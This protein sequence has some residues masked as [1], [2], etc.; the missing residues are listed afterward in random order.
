MQTRKSKP[1]DGPG[2]LDYALR[3]L[4]G[5]ALSLAEMR[6]RLHRRA[7]TPSDVE[8]VLAKL[9]DAGY[10][11]DSRFAESYATARRDTQGFG[12][13][14]VLRDLRTRKVPGNLA[15]Q[16]VRDAFEEVDETAM[17][18]AYLARKY[19]TVDLA[20][21][22]AE[23]KHLASAYRRLRLAGFSSTVSIRVLKQYAARAEELADEPEEEEPPAEG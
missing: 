1:L 18:E 12:Q 13:A 8:E 16:A 3:T 9:K 21:Y 23:E 6:T 2:L 20:V 11:D 19:R 17:V 22:L 7:L 14:R 15:D 5:R 4:T 10:L